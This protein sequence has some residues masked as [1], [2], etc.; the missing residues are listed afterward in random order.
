MPNILNHASHS[1]QKRTGIYTK[2]WRFVPLICHLRDCGRAMNIWIMRA[3]PNSH[4]WLIHPSTTNDTSCQ[5]NTL[6]SIPILSFSEYHIEV[7][8]LF[9]IYWVIL[10]GFRCLQLL[11]FHVQLGKP[12]MVAELNRSTRD[13]AWMMKMTGINLGMVPYFFLHQICIVSSA[14]SGVIWL[15]FIIGLF[16]EAVRA[17]I[18]DTPSSSFR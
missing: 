2:Y 5:A 6:L 1:K 3:S 18:I 15:V 10:D 12:W 11:K 16:L 8:F 14:R 9:S 17:T 7:S 13:A 4:W